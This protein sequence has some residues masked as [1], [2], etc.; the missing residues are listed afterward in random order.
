[1]IVLTNTTAQTLA[2]GAA[3]AFDSVVVKTKNGCECHRNNSAVVKLCQKGIYQ[4]NF[5]ANVGGGAG[6]QANLAIADG[7]ERLPETAMVATIEAATDVYNVAASTALKHCCC[8]GGRIT[9]I[10]T[11]TTPVVVQPNSAL[12]I[13][14]LA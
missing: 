7:G 1:M 12:F 4:I 9:V 3:L 13:Q 6:T 11:G 5:K 14:R 8:D 10:N 2:A